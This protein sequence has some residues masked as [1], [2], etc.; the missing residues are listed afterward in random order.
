MKKKIII[1]ALTVLILLGTKVEAQTFKDLKG[2]WAKKQIEWA[3]DNK[4]FTGYPD[5]RFKPQGTTTRAEFLTIVSNIIGN[6]YKG[7]P[8]SF[9]DVPSK[10]WYKPIIENLVGWKIVK[11]GDYIKPDAK[12]TRDEVFGIL[13]QLFPYRE[14]YAKLSFEDN[15]TIKRHRDIGVLKDLGIVNG[16][17]Y[18]RI[19]SH[20]GI[21]R[22]EIATILY[23]MSNKNIEVEKALV[24]KAREE[25]KLNFD[26]DETFNREKYDLTYKKL[27]ATPQETEAQLDALFRELDRQNPRWTYKKDK[28]F[29][30]D[31]NEL[32]MDLQ[33]VIEESPDRMF[34]KN[35]LITNEYPS[36]DIK[37]KFEYSV[38]QEEARSIMNTIIEIKQEAEGKSDFEKAKIIHDW[39][40]N[41]TRYAYDEYL[42]G[43]YQV[44]KNITAYMP[45]SIFKYRKGVCQAYAETF[46]I[47]A[48][49]VGL[50]SVII[51]GEAKNK[52]GWGGHAW[53]LVNIDGKLYHIDTTWDDPLTSD[54]RDMIRYKY[55]LIDDQTMSLDHKWQ[56]AEYPTVNN[57]CLNQGL[58]V[59]G[60][61]NYY[62]NVNNINDNNRDNNNYEFF[63]NR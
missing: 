27:V 14:Q 12:I 57:G 30:I 8:I 1:I 29:K 63:F 56:R 31:T 19:N 45:I 43:N 46:N 21:T 50:P 16:D 41:N 5:G 34:L 9:K 59:E 38:P 6:D 48:K 7:S 11:N 62:N 15:F 47:L 35:Y 23:I 55:F 28:K 54:G 49:E 51:S 26:F 53:N 32:I 36:G 58:D 24:Q 42:S 22:A 44:D 2:H 10:M 13:G 61:N 39:I 17:E 3:V 60:Y 25:N 18:N 33:R 4:L 20:E 40:V 52:R 37:F